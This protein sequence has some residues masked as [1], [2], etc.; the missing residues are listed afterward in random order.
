MSRFTSRFSAGEHKPLALVGVLEDTRRGNAATRQLRD[1][2]HATTNQGYP[3]PWS[4]NPF[5][6]AASARA[7]PRRT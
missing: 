7:S 6:A 2:L 3:G 1:A 5:I 4:S